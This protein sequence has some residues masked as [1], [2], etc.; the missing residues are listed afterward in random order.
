[1]FEE[2]FTDPTAPPILEHADVDV[3][4][5]CVALRDRLNEFLLKAKAQDFAESR[6]APLVSPRSRSSSR[7]RWR[8]LL[9]K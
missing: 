4:T 3:E 2:G 5:M 6:A 9:A 8:E 1:M 7:G